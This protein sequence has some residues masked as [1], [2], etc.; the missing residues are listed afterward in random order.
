MAQPA[1]AAAAGRMGCARVPGAARTRSRTR[2]RDSRGALRRVYRP[3]VRAGTRHASQLMRTACC[4]LRGLDS[5]PAAALAGPSCECL[6]HSFRERRTWPAGAT[7]KGIGGITRWGPSATTKRRQ[8]GRGPCVWHPVYIHARCASCAR[9]VAI[10][11]APCEAR[12][13]RHTTAVPPAGGS[14]RHARGDPGVPR[15]WLR[16]LRLRATYRCRRW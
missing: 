1:V 8:Q 7:R 9:R 2:R 4:A 10:H 14:G 6:F 16:L 15:W 11:A 5:A 12:C 3:H 13:D